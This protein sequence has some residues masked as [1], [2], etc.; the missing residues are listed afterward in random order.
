MLLKRQQKLENHRKIINND[1]TKKPDYHHKDHCH[2]LSVLYRRKTLWNL[3]RNV[4]FAKCGDYRDLRNSRHCGLDAYL[5]KE[6]Q[7]AF[8]YSR[9]HYYCFASNL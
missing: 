5:E 9:S 2:L 1:V 7:L 4:V 6:I 3:Y 8:R